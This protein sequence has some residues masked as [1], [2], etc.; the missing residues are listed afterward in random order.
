MMRRNLQYADCDLY[1]ESPED[2]WDTVRSFAVKFVNDLKP[3]LVVR[4][5]ISTTDQPEGIAMNTSE[6]RGSIKQSVDRSNLYGEVN[7]MISGGYAGLNMIFDFGGVVKVQFP[8]C[9]M[10]PT[11]QP[12][13]GTALLERTTKVL[14]V[15]GGS[16]LTEAEG[17]LVT[18]P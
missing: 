7:S 18:F 12:I 2:E 5:Y 9:V 13:E 8:H 1:L 11:E 10:E 3:F 15:F 14:C 16:V 4:N 17:H 6:V